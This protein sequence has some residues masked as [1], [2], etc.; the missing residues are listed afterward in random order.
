VTLSPLQTVSVT[1][2]PGGCPGE[3]QE[4]AE[5]QAVGVVVADVLECTACATCGAAR[6]GRVPRSSSSGCSASVWDRRV[7]RT[8][9]DVRS[10]SPAGIGRVCA[11]DPGRAGCHYPRSRGRSRAVWGP[12]ENSFP[13]PNTPRSPSTASSHPHR[14]TSAEVVPKWLVAVPGRCVLAAIHV[15][16][17]RGFICEASAHRPLPCEYCVWG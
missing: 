1:A 10:A 2:T 9:V 4:P 8:R 5:Q 11:G 6:T 15:H 17:H 3:R 14:S 13:L 16:C 12:P 7:R